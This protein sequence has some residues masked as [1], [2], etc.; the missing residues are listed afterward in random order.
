LLVRIFL[1]AMIRR[2]GLIKPL[3]WSTWIAIVGVA[4][5]PLCSNTTFLVIGGS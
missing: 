4:M 3:I 5:T 1:P 2:F